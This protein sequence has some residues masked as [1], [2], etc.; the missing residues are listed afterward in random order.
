L[1]GHP[2]VADAAVIGVPDAYRGEALQAWV[3]LRGGAQPG[4]ALQDLQALCAERLAR[5]KQP[6]HWRVTD[7]LPKTA[8]NK[9][10]KLALRRSAGTADRP[11]QDAAALPSAPRSGAAFTPTPQGDSA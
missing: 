8:A 11:S 10:D 4:P 2:E 5:Y 3:V 9:T 7:A 1:F 6:A